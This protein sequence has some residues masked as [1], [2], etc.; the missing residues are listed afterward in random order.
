MNFE[1]HKKLIEKMMLD[2][3]N[4]YEYSSVFDE[5][6]KQTTSAEV[7]VFENIKCKLSQDVS[8]SGT[9]KTSKTENGYYSVS[10]NIKLFLPTNVMVKSNSKIEVTANGVTSIFINASEPSFFSTHTELTL[11]LNK[12][13]A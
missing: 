2:T 6:T 13:R 12:E 11:V 9:D 10:K 3:C 4:I 8:I 7:L 5:T 1:V